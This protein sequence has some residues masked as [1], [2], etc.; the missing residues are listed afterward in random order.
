M[1][2]FNQFWESSFAGGVSGGVFA[3]G[4][5]SCMCIFILSGVSTFI[6]SWFQLVP[7]MFTF[8]QF[9]WPKFGLLAGLLQH[10]KFLALSFWTSLQPNLSF[11]SGF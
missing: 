6:S 2:D 9:W 3:A 11:A 10:S 4:S 8:N 5:I 7:S 1:F